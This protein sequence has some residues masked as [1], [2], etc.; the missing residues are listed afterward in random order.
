MELI[1]KTD[2]N[3]GDKVWLMQNNKP[4]EA[5]VTSITI[6]GGEVTDKGTSSKFGKTTYHINPGNQMV[7][8]GSSFYSSYEALKDAVFNKE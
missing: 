2:Y 4:V 7:Y 1:I 6:E 3:I 8:D 5:T